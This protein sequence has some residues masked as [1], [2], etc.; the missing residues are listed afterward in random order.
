MPLV[1]ELLVWLLIVYGAVLSLALA[2]LSRRVRLRRLREKRA[3]KKQAG[4]LSPKGEGEV[5]D[6]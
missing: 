2:W 6:G 3:G 5:S 1:I 4:T